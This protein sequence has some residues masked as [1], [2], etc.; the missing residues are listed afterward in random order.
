MTDESLTDESLTDE[1]QLSETDRAILDLEAR[2]YRSV[3]AKERDILRLTGLTPAQYHA[4]LVRLMRDPAAVRYAPG[5]VRR[6]LGR[7]RS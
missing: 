1:P 3:G 4:R 5:V 7:T 6:L 2:V